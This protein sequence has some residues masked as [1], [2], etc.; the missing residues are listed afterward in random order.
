MI[1]EYFQFDDEVDQTL[2]TIDWVTHLSWLILLA[3]VYQLLIL[4]LCLEGCNLEGQCFYE[5]A[6]LLDL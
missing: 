2:F 3:L 4:Y 5:L 1:H 6:V